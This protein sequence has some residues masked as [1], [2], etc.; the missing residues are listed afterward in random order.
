MAAAA[1]QHYLRNARDDGAE[2]TGPGQSPGTEVLQAGDRTAALTDEMRMV[3]SMSAGRA[4]LE[5]PGMIA[6]I[7][8]RQNLCL[9]QIMKV[10]KDGYAVDASRV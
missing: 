10:A 3:A 5:A 6:D 4:K 1:A 7:N 9:G 2:R 8:P